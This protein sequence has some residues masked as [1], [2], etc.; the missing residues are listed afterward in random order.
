[1]EL[2]TPL[3]MLHLIG[4]ALGV[5]AATLLDLVIIRFM[6]FGKISREHVR[7]VHTSAQVVAIGLTLLWASGL[8]FLLFYYLYAPANLTNEKIYAKMVIVLVLTI[9]GY[10]IHRHILPLIKQNVGRPLFSGVSDKQRRVML[11]AGAISA[12]SWYVPLALG[13]LR[14]LNFT[15]GVHILI[16]YVVLLMVTIAMAQ[17]AGQVMA[18]PAL[19]RNIPGVNK[20]ALV[21][22][23]TESLSQATRPSREQWPAGAS[24]VTVARRYLGLGGRFAERHIGPK[25]ALPQAFADA[26]VLAVFDRAAVAANRRLSELSHA[27]ANAMAGQSNTPERDYY[28]VALH[29]GHHAEHGDKHLELLVASW[30]RSSEHKKPRA[31][32]WTQLPAPGRPPAVAEHLNRPREI[33]RRKRPRG[34]V[35]TSSHRGPLTRVRISAA[36]KQLVVVMRR[37][38]RGATPFR[39]PAACYLVAE[40]PVPARPLWAKIENN[41][42]PLRRTSV[43]WSS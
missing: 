35:R 15:S 40:T 21:R 11:A 36:C 39:K 23:I 22:S 41:G 20:L 26:V 3:I 2:K 37:L 30:L 27:Q 5:G 8:G 14:E 43:S 13:V 16:F 4:L 29:G 6:V 1:M 33:K 10:V 19:L 18:T 31:N 17:V 9:N 38:W 12:T 28:D 25:H 24:R 34:S 7:I 32:K 42:A